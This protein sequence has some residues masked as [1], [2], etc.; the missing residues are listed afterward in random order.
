V[1]EITRGELKALKAF[2]KE[3]GLRPDWHEPDESEVTAVLRG[4]SFDNASPLPNTDFEEDLQRQHEGGYL[5][6]HIILKVEGKPVFCINLACLLA[7]AC[8][9]RFDDE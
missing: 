4:T 6:K 9:A 8:H 2:A 3:Y 7:L 5:E 1:D